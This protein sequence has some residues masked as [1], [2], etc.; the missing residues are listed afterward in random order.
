MASDRRDRRNRR[1]RM[2]GDRMKEAS[3]G[4]DLSAK[5][6]GFK[7]NLERRLGSEEY[8]RIGAEGHD[9]PDDAG[10]YNAAEVISEFR[11]SDKTVEEMT[12]YYQGLAD[13]GTKFNQRARDYL[14]KK[15]VT[16]G[17]GG[18]GGDDEV[19]PEPSP[20]PTPTPTDPPVSIPTP[21][22]GPDQSIDYKPPT[23]SYPGGNS[24][25]QNINQDNDI[26]T[27]ISGDNNTVTNNQDNSIAMYGGSNYGAYGSADR[28]KALRN[29]YVADVSRFVRA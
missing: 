12:D 14:K 10:R 29:Q 2:A 25:T 19:T 15:G 4:A 22:E 24:Q 27:T 13:D 17:G 6:E 7:N 20:E 21:V 28:A 26:T 8:G 9:A 5:D 23:L 3:E 16:F 18:D 1:N 11:N